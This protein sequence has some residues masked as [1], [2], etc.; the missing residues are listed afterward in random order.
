MSSHVGESAV[1]HNPDPLNVMIYCNKVYAIIFKPL[2]HI[3]YA[4]AVK[5]NKAIILSVGNKIIFKNVINS[6]SLDLLCTCGKQYSMGTFSACVQR[7]K[8][9]VKIQL[10]LS[11]AF[12]SI[13]KK[14]GTNHILHKKTLEICVYLH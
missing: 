7:C 14:A 11:L 10:T 12:I 2:L 9:K 13:A 8:Q 4:K 3:L 6:V 1:C 5:N